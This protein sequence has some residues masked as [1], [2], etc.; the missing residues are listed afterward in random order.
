MLKEVPGMRQSHGPALPA[1]EQTAVA[2]PFHYTACGLD[3]V[4]LL[5][6]FSVVHTPYGDGVAV[7]DSDGLHRVLAHVIVTD[8]RPVAAWELRFLR[9]HMGLSQNGLAQLLGSSDQ[10]V[11]RWEKR[12]SGIDPAAERLVRLLVLNWLK[13]DRDVKQ[14]LEDLAEQDEALHGRRSM[15]R[16]EAGW[17]RV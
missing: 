9:K 10:R 2:E 6:G 4:W 1:S 16:G 17:K 11:A 15:C 8:K 3:D 14:A 13:E 5:N 12:Q 7:E